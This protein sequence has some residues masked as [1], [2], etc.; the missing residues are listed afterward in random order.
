MMEAVIDYEE[1]YKSDRPSHTV[2]KKENQNS[3]EIALLAEIRGY[4]AKLDACEPWAVDVLAGIMLD[5]KV[6][7]TARVAAANMLDRKSVV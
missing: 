3:K 5:D 2:E 6:S 1:M 4:E 7:A